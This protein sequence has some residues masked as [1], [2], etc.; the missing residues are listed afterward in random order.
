MEPRNPRRE[1]VAPPRARRRMRPPWSQRWVAFAVL[2]LL[3]GS[4]LGYTVAGSVT[5]LHA[6]E[7]AEGAYASERTVPGW[8]WLG[9]SYWLTPSPA[10]AQLSHTVG[11]PTVLGGTAAS[12]LVNAGT[13]GHAAISWNYTEEAV[14]PNS[15]EF[16]FTF[17]VG[18]SDLGSTS[19][20]KAYLETQ[21]LHLVALNFDLFFDLGTGSST[22]LPIDTLQ[23]TVQQCS[24][25]GTC[26]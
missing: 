15:T 17:K 25:N 9:V 20:V 24:S 7:T 13:A 3:L 22:A 6:T 5:I 14:L 10:P 19:V 11:T 8:T 12:Y 2:A 1:A 26:P 23:V 4:A 21:L 18:T 16:E